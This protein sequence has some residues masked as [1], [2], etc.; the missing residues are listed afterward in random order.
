VPFLDLNHADVYYTDRGV[1]DPPI[2]LVHGR[3]A[4]GACWDWHIE[5]LAEHHRVIAYDSVNHGFSSN[6]P[7]GEPE[8]D[9]CGEL[10]E[11]L[12]RLSVHR[13]ILVGQSMGAMTVLRWAVRHQ[14]A[15]RGIVV[16][17]MGW[18]MPPKDERTPT[19]PL[20]DGL[21]IETMRF[22]PTWSASHGIEVERYS[23]LRST[24]TAIEAMRHPRDMGANLTEFQDPELGLGLKRLGV[25]VHVF[26]GANDYFASSAAT[27][28]EHVPFCEV[29]M[30]PDA[31]HSA[32]IQ[33]SEV[34]TEIVLRMAR[35]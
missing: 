24:A 15:C 31:D 9:R 30:I 23:R 27:V 1:G 12:Q 13:P 16:A 21:W 20:R 29:T 2:V 18:P 22:D 33:E 3:S 14:G 34:L 8:P 4:S 6:S 26:M 17:G 10:T 25:P 7:R 35:I 19:P 28:A 32:Y 11:V 5:R